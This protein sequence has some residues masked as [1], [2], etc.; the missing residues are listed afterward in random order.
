MDALLKESERLTNHADVLDYEIAVAC[1]L[2]CGLIDVFFVG[3]LDL[4]TAHD[5]GSEKVNKFVL[6]VASHTKGKNGRPYRGNDIKDAIH[7]LEKNFGAPSDNVTSQFGGG[8]Q[9]HL[10][11]FAHH[12]SVTGLVFSLL[13]QFTG[14]AYGTDTSGQFVVVDLTEKAWIGKGFPE[15]L[16]F[17]IVFWFFHMVSDMAG[18][19]SHAGAGT[20]LPGPIL[21]LA[22]QLSSCPIFKDENG[23]NTFSKWI[24]KAFNGTLTAQRDTN[25][26]LIKE[27]I[28]QIDLRTEL[29][30]IKQ[31][32][33]PVILNEV[34]VR[35]FYFIS[36]IHRELEGKD[37]HC[38]NELDRLD[39]DKCIPVRNR[40]IIRM[41]TV[42][43]SSF[44]AVDLADAAICAAS[45]SGG[46][47]G[48][49]V[50]QLLLRVNFV[51]IG[52]MVLSIGTELAMEWKRE[53]IQKKINFV[54]VK[55]LHA[56]TDLL[57][58]ER[59]ELEKIVCWGIS[60]QISEV[61]AI[62]MAIEKKDTNAV[63]TLTDQY[64][65]KHHLN[66]Q[67]ENFDEFQQFMINTHEDLIL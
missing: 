30:I 28:Y 43:S 18:S 41:L 12:P 16:L 21:S 59:I 17:G 24:S 1:G 51:G 26:K 37:I 45:K 10:R 47:T 32:A 49:F 6:H 3:E 61:N 34:L 20:G 50:G 56:Y 65:E 48:V 15:K 33:L 44:T 9:H 31:Q 54:I 8:R 25:G 2:F 40:T 23:V 57:R 29:G 38:L 46:N 66:A 19:S 22:K 42:A 35:G 39:W 60:V 27:S 62:T 63:D 64:L 7:H 13:T 53:E 14:K 55:E 67:F 36:R 5:W 11:D 58:A 52:R 4:S